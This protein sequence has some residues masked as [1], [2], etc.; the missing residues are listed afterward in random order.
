MAIAGADLRLVA[1][2]LWH[3]ADHD[4]RI[5]FVNLW[6]WV[7]KGKAAEVV[8]RSDAQVAKLS[9]SDLRRLAIDC[10]LVDEVRA[11]PYDARKPAKL[12]ETAKRLRVNLEEIRK[13]LKG[14]EAAKQIDRRGKKSGNTAGKSIQVDN[15]RAPLDP[16]GKITF[17]QD[18]L[19]DLFYDLIEIRHAGW[20]NEDGACGDFEWDLPTDALRHVHN[21]RFTDYDTTEHEGL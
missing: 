14:E 9:E 13:T 4:S 6:G 1:Q 7:E 3:R 2:A 8:Y 10:A 21:E 15:E 20:E 12:L 19:M 11:S 16:T 5:R 18:Q 17:T